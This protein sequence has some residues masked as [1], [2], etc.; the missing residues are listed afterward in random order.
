MKRSLTDDE[1][2]RASNVEPQET[3]K[4]RIDVESVAVT[5]QDF[6]GEQIAIADYGQEAN[7]GYGDHAESIDIPYTNGN[8]LNHDLDFEDH[9]IPLNGNLEPGNDLSLIEIAT[10]NAVDNNELME[11]PCEVEQ[12][13]PTLAATITP[14][15]EPCEDVKEV[16]Q[17]KH[18][19]HEN[20]VVDCRDL[21]DRASCSCFEGW[22]QQ[23]LATWVLSGHSQIVTCVAMDAKTL[24]TASTDTTLLVWDLE[25]RNKIC[26]LG[27]H[28]EEVM[29]VCYLSKCASKDLISAFGEDVSG[30]IVISGSQDCCVNIWLIPEGRLLQSIY[31]FNNV[32]QVG[33][34]Q[35][36]KMVVTG[37][38]GG[39]IEVF[40]A[41]TKSAVDSVKAFKY[42]VAAL[43]VSGSMIFCGDTHSTIQLWKVKN[44][45]LHCVKSTNAL[46]CQRSS[47]TAMDLQATGVVTSHITGSVKSMSLL[48]GAVKKIGCPG[49]GKANAICVVDELLVA[50]T[51]DM[52]C[53]ALH[54]KY[55]Q[56]VLYLRDKI[57]Q[58]H[59]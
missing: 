24:I 39:K 30:Q 54:C 20:A 45:K 7:N 19:T 6:N 26:N 31:T 52:I 51:S 48:S 17:P 42:S 15:E 46:E 56:D 1:V 47:L 49:I 43:K 25:S 35:E 41:V 5:K 23:E 50:A 16:L 58:M 9:G 8:G 4:T 21:T 53:S 33:Y 27:G 34:L 28:K 11:P 10:E 57:H 22:D 14:T 29:S 12:S 2:G 18:S 32:W 59:F 55:N 36:E 44:K 3:K 37:T 13:N 40:D 38:D